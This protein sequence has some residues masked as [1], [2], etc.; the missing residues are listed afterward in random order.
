MLE[1][2]EGSCSATLPCYCKIGKN[3]LEHVYVYYPPSL[4]ITY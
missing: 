3:A 1:D 2:L 4:L